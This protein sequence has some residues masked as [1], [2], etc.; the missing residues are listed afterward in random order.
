MQRTDVKVV[1][2]ASLPGRAVEM[3]QSEGF[4]VVAPEQGRMSRPVQLREVQDADALISLLS[5][6]VDEELLSAA[7]RLRIVANYAAGFDNVDIACATKR[8]ILV[9][10]TPDVLT[11]ATADLTM[12]LLLAAARR[13]VEGDA[14]VRRGDF[15]GWAPE[16]LLGLDVHG[17]TLGI[18]GFGRIGRAVARRA[19]GFDMRI[20]YDD[21]RVAPPEVEI[22]LGA[23]RVTKDE[24]LRESDF[25]TLQC[26]LTRET[27]GYLGAQ[28][29]MRMKRTAILV[30]AARGP[31]VDEAA[32]ARALADGTIAGAALDVY[33][34]EPK[35]HPA[36]L[37]QKRVVLA[38]HVGSATLAT[39]SKMGEICA[40]AVIAAMRGD[41]PAHLVN[42]EAWGTGRQD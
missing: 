29:F 3:L 21:T 25:V 6:K 15:N 36:L 35:V 14:L 17:A 37:E 34:E 40:T 30:N 31:L 20:L 19:R 16:L 38:P 27:K 33:E 24:L 10:N 26:P 39:R 32:L 23:R 9:T 41:K 13:V 7:K 5:D 22:A 1:I 12:A 2:T 8:G 42:P 18:V 28:D 4:V 11:E